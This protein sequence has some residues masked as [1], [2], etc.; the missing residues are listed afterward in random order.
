MTRTTTAGGA[1]AS[2][3]P[4]TLQ[5]RT[6][7]RVL[8]V[9]LVVR[10]M[11]LYDTATRYPHDWLYNRG[12]EMGLLANSLVHGLGYSSPFG[13]TTGP[14]AFIA[15]GYPTLVAA[16]FLLFGS[17]TFASAIVIMA[18]QVFVSVLT[19]GLMMRARSGRSPSRCFISPQFFGRRA[20]QPALLSEWWRWLCAAAALRPWRGGCCL[21]RPARSPV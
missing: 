21:A 6:T 16:I 9:A 5:R 7:W 8:A 4:E 13:G 20:S 12:I 11:V 14:T 15:P 17:Y 3:A 10:M 1:V 19:V 18:L 2:A